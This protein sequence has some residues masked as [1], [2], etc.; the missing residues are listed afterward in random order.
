MFDSVVALEVS[1]LHLFTAVRT[2]DLSNK[3]A[4]SATT[5]TP[6]YKKNIHIFFSDLPLISELH[7]FQKNLFRIKFPKNSLSSS[8]CSAE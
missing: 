3:T 5:E 2:V 6:Y 4:E 7:N 1:L 8:I